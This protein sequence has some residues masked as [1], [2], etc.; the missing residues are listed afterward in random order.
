M[1]NQQPKLFTKRKYILA[2]TVLL[3]GSSLSIYREY[4]EIGTITGATIGASVFALAMG[5]GILIFIGRLAN[6]INN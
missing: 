5:S 1:A 2:F 4:S 3:V 6:K